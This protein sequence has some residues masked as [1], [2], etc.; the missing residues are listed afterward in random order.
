VLQRWRQVQES[1]GK[2]T[3]LQSTIVVNT[4]YN[5]GMNEFLAYLSTPAGAELEHSIILLITAVAA[6]LS[7]VAMEISR[8]N[9]SKLNGHME[10]HMR[11]DAEH[12]LRSR[13]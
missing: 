5:L 9:S 12:E 6:I 10:Q 4:L 13:D 8:R 3:L 11:H 2:A 7:A 1:T